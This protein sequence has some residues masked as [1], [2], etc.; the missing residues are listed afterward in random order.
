[1]IAAL[2]RRRH[3]SRGVGPE[4]KQVR[5]VETRARK[6]G[7]PATCSSRNGDKIDG[8]I[9]S[10]PNYGEER[11]RWWR[12]SPGR[13]CMVGKRVAGYR[14]QPDSAGRMNDRRPARQLQRQDV[15]PVNNLRQYGIPV[16]PD[17]A[18]PKPRIRRSFRKD[19]EWFTALCRVVKG[20]AP[21][22]R[23]PRSAPVRRPSNTVRYSEK[24]LE[25]AA[26]TWIPID[27]RRSSAASSG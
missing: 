22:A 14:L 20:H 8:I 19:L 21:H 12:R 3:R 5:A 13:L 27:L 2:K 26:S 17:H 4:E 10:L 25:R 7:M 6:Q 18:H 23:G 24:L 11:G 15:V 1:M 9:V 16:T